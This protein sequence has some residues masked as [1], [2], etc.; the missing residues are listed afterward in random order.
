MIQATLFEHSLII[1]WISTRFCHDSVI[2]IIVVVI[3]NNNDNNN[4]N[5]NDNNN[6]NNNNNNNNDDNNNNNNNDNNNNN[7]NNNVL[8]HTPVE[9]P[10]FGSLSMKF[11]TAFLA[12][13]F[14][15]VSNNVSRPRMELL[16]PLH[17]I[18]SLVMACFM[19]FPELKKCFLG[20]N[21]P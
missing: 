20:G 5:N 6:D 17:G 16:N 12:L 7:N 9:E 8:L 10:F 14:Y 1:P 2:I 13:P 3:I 21:S 11:R 4:N 15:R 18:F 19:E